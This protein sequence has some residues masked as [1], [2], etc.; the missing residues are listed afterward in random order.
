M[1]VYVI[2]IDTPFSHYNTTDINGIYTSFE[3]AKDALKDIEKIQKEKLSDHVHCY[4][5]AIKR[6]SKKG[7][8]Y[9]STRQ[10]VVLSA[11]NDFMDDTNQIIIKIQ[12]QPLYGFNK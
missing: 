6:S 12:E 10:T 1:Y 8:K 3:A 2:T 9:D 11:K 4:L 5:N 7:T